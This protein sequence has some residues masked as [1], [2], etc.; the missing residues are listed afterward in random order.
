MTATPF[1]AK[2]FWRFFYFLLAFASTFCNKN[3]GRA[4]CHYHRT[5]PNHSTT[6]GGAMADPYLTSE[7]RAN[8]YRLLFRL[9]RSFHLIVCRLPEAE[10]LGLMVPRD[11]K[12]MLG[13]TQEVQ[14]EINTTILNRLEYLE[15]EDHGHFGKVR[16]AM[17]KRLRE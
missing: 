7:E 12:D 1:R 14:L 16:I 9:N 10:A 17:E 5:R 2:S 4:R 15:N 6:L 3:N 13:M 8:A 11:T